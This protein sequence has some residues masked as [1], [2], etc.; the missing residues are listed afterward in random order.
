MLIYLGLVHKGANLTIHVILD[1]IERYKTRNNG[2][3]PRKIHIQYDGGGENANQSVVGWMQLI[4]AL[5]LTAEIFLTRLP[6]GH[7]HEDIDSLFGHIWFYLRLLAIMT[8]LHFHQILNQIFG[9]KVGFEMVDVN[10][11]ADYDSIMKE[12]NCKMEKWAKEELT[13]HQIHI[14]AVKPDYLYPL[15]VAFRYRDYASDK[16]VELKSVTSSEAVS[17]IARLTGIEPVTHHV[18]WFPDELNVLGIA[19]MRGIYTLREIP[20]IDHSVGISPV[21]FDIQDI[22]NLMATKSAII[23]CDLMPAKSDERQVWMDWFE[24]TLPRDKSTSAKEYIRSGHSYHQPLLKYLS[25]S[26]SAQSFSEN[27]L[28]EI[29]TRVDESSMPKFSWPDDVVSYAT[30]HVLFRSWQNALLPP[31]VYK[32]Q[33]A[34][35]Q[36]LAQCYTE[37]TKKYYSDMA[38]SVT[39]PILEKILIRRLDKQGKHHPLS[40]SKSDLMTRICS[41]DCLK[42]GNLYHPIR[43]A[44]DIA[45]LEE[46]FNHSDDQAQSTMTSEFNI[47]K[48]IFDLVKT[49]RAQISILAINKLMELFQVRENSLLVAYNQVYPETNA[50]KPR[51]KRNIYLASEI[52]NSIFISLRTEKIYS[53]AIEGY[54]NSQEANQIFI[55]IPGYR[56]LVVLSVDLKEVWFFNANE[57]LLDD[58]IKDM[59]NDIMNN[60]L[61][62]VPTLQQ[63]WTLKIHHNCIRWKRRGNLSIIALI[64]HISNDLPIYFEE[65]HLDNFMKQ[66]ALSIIK[67]DLQF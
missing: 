1:Q 6:T 21:D 41:S 60:L 15:G 45:L 27:I 32:Y 24:Q 57:A 42:F 26:V 12:S 29:K 20:T 36:I 52:G 25:Q 28:N 64:V 17:D 18:K 3:F 22:N 44:S 8:L 62:L 35:A 48:E 9:N 23:N 66:V 37:M 47:V 50:S 7:T 4:V 39:I 13:V 11:V 43:N 58:T 33:S 16:V 55:P 38:T 30:P 5:R 2:K 40:G 51:R 31:R 49:L 63:G 34:N 61:K 54:C 59:G 46:Y 67:N 10:V 19:E 14:F 56:S 53:D 65:D